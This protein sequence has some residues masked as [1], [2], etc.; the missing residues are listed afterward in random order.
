MGPT[1]VAAVN[2]YLPLINTILNV[3]IIPAMMM[4][5]SVRI[6][7]ARVDARFTALMEAYEKRITNLEL[8]R[9]RVK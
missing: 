9:D 7:L 1:N 3:L 8:L 4:L 6:E 5:W 2:E